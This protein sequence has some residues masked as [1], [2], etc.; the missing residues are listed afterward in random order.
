[1]L[2]RRREW[3]QATQ[4]HS[5]L[6]L[7]CRWLLRWRIRSRQ[8]LHPGE[9]SLWTT[10]DKLLRSSPA[11]KQHTTRLRVFTQ[12]RSGHSHD[13][14]RTHRVQHQTP[15]SPDVAPLRHPRWRQPR[16]KGPP[17]HGHP[18]MR[19]QAAFP[20]QCACRRANAAPQM[21]AA[22]ARHLQPG[23]SRRRPAPDCGAH[24][25]APRLQ[26]AA[27]PGC[28]HRMA[29]P[30]V[31]G[32]QSFRQRLALGKPSM[33]RDT[34]PYAADGGHAMLQMPLASA[35]V[36]APMPLRTGSLEICTVSVHT[37]LIVSR[38]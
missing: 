31:T 27:G 35:P 5:A 21:P 10:I 9:G 19:A 34:P 11:C 3:Q 14:E 8:R 4:H 20:G 7:S 29:A 33:P 30:A 23:K 17:W 12:G 26:A 38:E 15:R 16:P 13:R 24:W 1:M 28:L 6:H 18:V 32:H 25:E 37:C 22:E 36:P 2:K